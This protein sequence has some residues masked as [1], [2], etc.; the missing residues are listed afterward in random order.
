MSALVRHSFDKWQHN[1]VMKEVGA[2][3]TK[4]LGFITTPMARCQQNFIENWEKSTG[5]VALVEPTVEQK[6]TVAAAAN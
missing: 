5:E 1:L 6:P 2:F 4:H 3:R